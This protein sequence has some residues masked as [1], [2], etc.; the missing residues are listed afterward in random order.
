MLRAAAAFF[1]AFSIWLLVAQRVHSAAELV[2]GAGIA[3]A[4][5]LIGLHFGG[6]AS[7]GFARAPGMLWLG[8]SRGKGVISGSMLTARAALA[9]DVKLSPGLVRLKMRSDDPDVRADLAAL[10]SATP[11]A[12]VVDTDVEG[13]LIHLIDEDDADGHEL[14][15]LEAR[16]LTAHGVWGRQ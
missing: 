16:T 6:G 13:L 7:G 15:G 10:I 1:S 12:V 2:L 4:A 8:A 5:V 3:A 9:G 11:G 14:S